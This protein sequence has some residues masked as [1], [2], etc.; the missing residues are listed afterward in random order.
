MQL[1]EVAQA[2]SAATEDTQLFQ[3]VGIVRR[4]QPNW[5]ECERGGYRHIGRTEE[6]FP[7]CAFHRDATAIHL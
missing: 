7:R 4:K 3:R 6:R 5:D 2:Q 1:L